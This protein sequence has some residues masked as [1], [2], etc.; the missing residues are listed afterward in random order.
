[1][2]PILPLL[3]TFMER[4]RLEVGAVASVGGTDN[5]F[6]FF[7]SGKDSK[8]GIPIKLTAQQIYSILANFEKIDDAE[9][10]TQQF[11]TNILERYKIELLEVEIYRDRANKTFNAKLLFY[12]GES[13]VTEVS[14][15]V[16]GAILAKKFQAPIYITAKEM[17]VYAKSIESIGAINSML[18]ESDFDEFEDLESM[19]REAIEK[20]EDERA[21]DIKAEIN[22]INTKNKI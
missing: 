17:Q 22:R 20:E 11:M 12:D 7:L 10:T 6:V 2:L 9:I 15:A 18:D 16:D 1:M 13:E 14:S 21:A 5:D 3:K 8:M 19:L 4:V